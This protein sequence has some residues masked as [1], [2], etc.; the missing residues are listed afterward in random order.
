[1]AVFPGQ[2]WPQIGLGAVPNMLLNTTA[3]RGVSML[4]R[5]SLSVQSGVGAGIAMFTSGKDWFIKV[6]ST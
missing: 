2:G 5:H 4:I 3:G 1:M 6:I